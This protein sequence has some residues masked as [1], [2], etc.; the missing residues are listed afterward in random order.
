[1][2]TNKNTES[3]PSFVPL[4]APGHRIA[5][6]REMKKA[7][8]GTWYFVDYSLILRKNGFAATDWDRFVLDQ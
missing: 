4:V 2:N 8:D 1:M 3:Y 7:D 6:V 5:N